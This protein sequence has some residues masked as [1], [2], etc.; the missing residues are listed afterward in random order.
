MNKRDLLLWL[1]AECGELPAAL[2]KDCL[3]S[4]SYAAALITELKKDGAI[5]VR[6]RDGLKGYV[7]RIKG[8]KELSEKYPEEYAAFCARQRNRG[9]V[10]SD[11]CK[12][13]RMHRTAMALVFFFR[14]GAGVFPWEKPCFPPAPDQLS[15]VP[16]YYQA[17]EVKGGSDKV[18]G[19]RACGI[20]AARERAFVV[21]HTMERRMKWSAKMETAMKTFA[22]NRLWRQ[23]WQNSADALMIGNTMGELRMLLKS[24]GGFRGGLFRP[25][26]AYEH[27]YFLP[28][29]ADCRVQLALLTDRRARERLAYFLGEDSSHF[30][31]ELDLWGLIYTAREID[32]H[33]GGNV[34]CLD[35]QAEALRSFF[36]DTAAVKPLSGEKVM[37]FLKGGDGK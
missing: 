34:Y 2:I 7:L 21:Y 8:R 36:G 29:E 11:V 25:D 15:D 22:E 31:C 35:Y 16:S 24:D 33:G 37:K 19:S 5:S 10:K 9:H 20:L 13:L 1:T 28:M 12:R 26:E 30:C 17:A 14:H 32:R 6:S 18:T 4:Q 23:G 3:G 27:Y